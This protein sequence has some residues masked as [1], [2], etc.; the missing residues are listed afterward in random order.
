MTLDRYAGWL[1]RGRAHQTQGR[2]IDAL[3]C[4]RRALNEDAAAVDARFHLGE[5]AWHLG[6]RAGAIEAWQSTLSLSPAHLPSLH[7]LCDA[8]AATGQFDGALRAARRVL[9]AKPGLPRARTLAAMAQAALGETVDDAALIEALR[10]RADW[11]LALLSAVGT[12]VLAAERRNAH[13]GAIDELLVAVDR[14]PITAGSEDVLRLLAVQ[15]GAAGMTPAAETFADRYGRCCEAFYGATLPLPWPR[16]TA[17]REVRAGMLVSAGELPVASAMI[18][19]LD[20]RSPTTRCRWIVFVAGGEPSLPDRTP[21]G[22]DIRAVPLQPEAAARALALLDLD[23]LVDMAG[24]QLPSGPLLARKPARRIWS[25]R[26]GGLPLASALAT[27]IIDIGTPA[28]DAALGDAL[29]ALHGD[30][31]AEPGSTMRADELATLWHRAVHAHQNGDLPT[32][33]ADYATIMADQPGS[34]ATLYL[35]GQV[36]RSTGDVDFARRAFRRTV[37]V[38]PRFADARAALVDAEVA[39]RDIDAAIAAAKAGLDASPDSP[40]L[41]RA[42]GSAELRRGDAAAAERAFVEALRRNPADGETHYNHGVALQTARK[43]AEAARAYQRAV[44]I[45]PD[46]YAAD[47]NLGVIFD[48]QGNAD[49]AIAAFANVIARAPSH[50][51]AYK[52]LADTLLASGR[53]D[54]WFANFDRF[55]RNCPKHVALAALALEVC[56]YRADFARLATYVDG[57]RDD[58]FVEG[59][60]AEVLDALQVIVYLLHFFDVEPELIGRVG[61]THDAVARK[62]Y[63]EPRASQHRRSGKL[64]IGYL[65]GDFRNHVMGKMMWEALRHHDRQRFDVFGYATGDAPRD[66]WTQRYE[67][68]FG[69]LE[70]LDALTDRE[71]ADRIAADDVDVLVDLS[72]HTKGARPG[73]LALKP[74]R[75]QL[76][77]VASAGSLAMAAIDFKLTDRYA[78]VAHDPQAQLEPLLVMEGCVYP[79]RHVAASATVFP[80]RERLGLAATAVVIGAF[81]TPM[82][83]S[84]RC[85]ALWRDVV[86]RI[87]QAVLAFS[88]LQPALRP[89]FQRICAAG[90]IDA[91]RIVFIPQGRDDAENQ[92]R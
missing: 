59:E 72:T 77:H 28:A 45:R 79:Y 78:D 71:A 34:A 7:A 42:L 84:Q 3:L 64:R 32:A 86:R 82:K 52:A 6:D 47:F 5:I 26:R 65:S 68:L 76:T 4:Y 41:W 69:R 57:L 67:T 53:I 56:A 38:A 25:V 83:L 23:V 89:V 85:L 24:L 87:P 29:D 88:P 92:A 12:H 74:A 73:V 51:A 20:A 30:V 15:L 91:N 70:Q 43:P 80:T 37:D 49:A 35:A 90:G 22:V 2:A 27:R 14:A 8:L 48:Q 75:V 46:L 58:R 1:A 9:D 63:G 17:G 19:R 36:A 10:S 39:G 81:C 21:E 31:V 50:A 55:E 40:A 54:A 66:G 18:A 61:R 11:P 62:I 44:A 60:P 16:R 13:A 33:A